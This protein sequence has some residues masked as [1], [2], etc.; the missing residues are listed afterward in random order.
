MRTG[1]I[2]AIAAGAMLLGAGCATQAP[3]DSGC[4]APKCAPCAP[5]P[6]CKGL[7]SCKQKSAPCDS[8]NNGCR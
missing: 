8:C 7:C 1:L 4:C 5:C 2:A 3:C 6:S